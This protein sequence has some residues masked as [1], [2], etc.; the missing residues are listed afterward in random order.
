MSREAPGTARTGTAR[1]SKRML[2]YARPF[3]A[4]LALLLAFTLTA[5]GGGDDD[6]GKNAR[7]ATAAPSAP[8]RTGGTTVTGGTP[9]AEVDALA[10]LDVPPELWDGASLGSKSAK[11]TLTLFEDFQCPFCLRFTANYDA[12]IIEEYVKPGRV[13]L[14]FKHF[15]ILGEESTRAAVSAVCAAQVNQFWALHNRLFLEQ[16]KAGQARAEKTNVG[17]FS[18]PNLRTFALESGVPTVTYDSCVADP[19]TVLAVQAD[20]A[21]GRDIGIRGTPGVAING[22]GVTIP[23]SASELR[24]LLDDAIAAAR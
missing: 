24:R 22:K 17:R 19:A 10:K 8:V 21:L 18:A 13:R 16:A 1:V 2:D 4:A 11:V 12:I 9:S 23:A 3:L 6:S 15:P 5:C 14:E 20:I 7:E